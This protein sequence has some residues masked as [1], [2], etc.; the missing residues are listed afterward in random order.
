MLV[1][2]ASKVNSEFEIIP[3]YGEPLMLSN[4]VGAMSANSLTWSTNNVDYYL[5]SNDLTNSEM[6]TVAHSLTV[7]NMDIGK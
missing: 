7:T 6:L 1:E 5:T 2:E 3:V 4:S